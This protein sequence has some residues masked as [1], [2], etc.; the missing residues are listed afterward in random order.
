MTEG[1]SNANHII[2]TTLTQP[3]YPSAY[4]CSLRYASEVILIPSRVSDSVSIPLTCR[5]GI[6]MVLTITPPFIF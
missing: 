2:I 5:V 3:Y 6:D 1:S 4:R